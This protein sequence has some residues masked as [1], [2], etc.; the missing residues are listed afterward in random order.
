MQTLFEGKSDLLGPSKGIATKLH[1]YLKNVSSLL[2]LLHQKAK[3][4]KD[5]KNVLDKGK[6]SAAKPAKAAIFH[7]S[8]ATGKMTGVCQELQYHN[9]IRQ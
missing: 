5:S 1:A 9:N 6:T 4:I 2:F 3:Q 8:S 7:L